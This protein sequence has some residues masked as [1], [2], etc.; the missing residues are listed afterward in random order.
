[1][2]LTVN[3]FLRTIPQLELHVKLQCGFVQKDS[4][5]CMYKGG[6][7]FVRMCEN[8]RVRERERERERDIVC[9]TNGLLIDHLVL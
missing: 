8:V 5:W 7:V 1:M 3:L 9:L 4:M 2:M 6:F